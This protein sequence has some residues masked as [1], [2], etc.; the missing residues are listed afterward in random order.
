MNRV[1]P[2]PAEL[3]SVREAVE[4]AIVT[5]RS[6]R[7]FRPQP[8]DVETVHK[9]LD[10]AR[11]A[12][13]GVNIQPWQVHV[14][15]GQA[16]D[17]ICAAIK[18]VD[19]DPAQ[20]GGHSDEWAYYPDEWVAPYLDRRRE[21]G[22]RLYG[23][24]GIEKGNKA[25]MHAQHGRNYQFFDAPVGLFFTVHRLMNEGSLIDYGMFLQNLMVVAR[26]YGLSTCPQAAFMKYHAIIRRELS[27]GAE[28][29]FLVG[30]SLGYADDERVEN[31]LVSDRAPASSFTVVHT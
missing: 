19:D 2:P 26:T 16:R 29:K 30:M 1:A 13:T 8:V 27:L 9:I 15:T 11:F 6:V 4:W 17:R 7:A 22:W 18:Q 23:L 14:V 21:V 20:S 24:L 3:Q 25:R 28:E 31:Q 5:R 12:A 10:V